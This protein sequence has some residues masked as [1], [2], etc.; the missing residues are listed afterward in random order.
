[1]T[2]DKLAA[3]DVA[4]DHWTALAPMPF[5]MLAPA[6]ATVNGQLYC[7]GGS[8]QLGQPIF[9]TKVQIYQP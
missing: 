7:I 6:S 5:A 4:A 8:P 2:S 3:Y 1:M 9:S